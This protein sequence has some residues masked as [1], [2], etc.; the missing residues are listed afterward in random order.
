[1]IYFAILTGKTADEDAA[2]THPIA[3][4]ISRFV[5]DYP[6]REH[7]F[8]EPWHES[9]E[10]LCGAGSARSE[11]EPIARATANSTPK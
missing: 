1:M 11:T 9:P 7:T 2:I 10:N 5:E 4:K 3:E 8:A 6:D